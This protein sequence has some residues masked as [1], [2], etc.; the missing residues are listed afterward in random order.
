[1]PGSALEDWFGFGR[2]LC[3]IFFIVFQ[4]RILVNSFAT[5]EVTVRFFQSKKNEDCDDL[6]TWLLTSRNPALL[7]S[8]NAISNSKKPNQNKQQ[9]PHKC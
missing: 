2:I 9:N 3:T 5:A 8:E 7:S 1:M 4:G 6:S